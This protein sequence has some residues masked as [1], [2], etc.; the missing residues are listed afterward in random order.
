MVEADFNGGDI[1]SNGDYTK[2][3]KLNYLDLSVEVVVA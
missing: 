2:L 3:R 1:S